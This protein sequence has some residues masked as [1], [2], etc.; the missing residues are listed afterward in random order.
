MSLL[1]QGLRNNMGKSS[2]EGM[3]AQLFGS[4][5]NAV[6]ARLPSGGGAAPP[7][8]SGAPVGAKPQTGQLQTLA[9]VAVML[10]VS[11]YAFFASQ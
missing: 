6:L 1:T 2:Y 7:E 9:A 5:S 3:K 11:Y 4:G 8:T 10:F